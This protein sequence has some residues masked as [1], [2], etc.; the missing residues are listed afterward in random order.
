MKTKEE[1]EKDLQYQKQRL[2]NLRLSN[3]YH[4]STVDMMIINHI[5][6]VIETEEWILSD[7]S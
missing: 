4:F 2:K 3:H 1:I 5:E 7:E 6:A